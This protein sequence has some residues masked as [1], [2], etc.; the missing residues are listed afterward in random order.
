MTL[1]PSKQNSIKASNI[2]LNSEHGCKN[3]SDSRTLGE[4]KSA[5]PIP[6][7]TIAAEQDRRTK[8][9]REGKGRQKDPDVIAEKDLA[10]SYTVKEADN[11][12]GKQQRQ[13]GNPKRDREI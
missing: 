12:V 3:S 2:V 9:H 4:G 1:L 6:T 10:S 7:T 5:Y 8:A 11:G 13:G